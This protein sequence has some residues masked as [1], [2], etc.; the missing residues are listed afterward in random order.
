MYDVPPWVHGPFPFCVLLFSWLCLIPVTVQ[1]QRTPSD[2]T[3][4]AIH[5]GAGSLSP[6]GMS[7][8]REHAYRASLRA[9]PQAGNQVLQGGGT[10]L[11]AVQAAVTTMESVRTLGV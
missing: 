10:A 5:G 2:A 7:E 4:F 3:A 9:A 11:D 8:S 1:G 6:D